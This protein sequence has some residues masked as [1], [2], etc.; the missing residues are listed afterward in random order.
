MHQAIICGKKFDSHKTITNNLKTIANNDDIA[1][2]SW[3]TIDFN[4]FKIH[5]IAKQKHYT[6][7]TVKNDVQSGTYK[8]NQKERFGRRKASPKHC[9]HHQLANQTTACFVHE[10]KTP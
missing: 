1:F 4:N 9:L 8:F 10:R 5:S 3:S 7:A 2:C 6:D